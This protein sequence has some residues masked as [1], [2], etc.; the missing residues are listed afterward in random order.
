M[1]KTRRID[2][3]AFGKWQKTSEYFRLLDVALQENKQ[4]SLSLLVDSH[5][6]VCWQY[7][8]LGKVS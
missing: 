5:L 6:L 2:Y 4:M 1:C 7:M 3:D 8:H